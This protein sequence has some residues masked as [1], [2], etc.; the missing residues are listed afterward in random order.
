M[1]SGLSIP[2]PQRHGV[3]IEYVTRRKK[4]R[5]YKE[6]TNVWETKKIKPSKKG[7]KGKR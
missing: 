3:V 4:I 6:A 7:R 1:V 2:W 5:I